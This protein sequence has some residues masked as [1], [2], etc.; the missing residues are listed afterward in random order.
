MNFMC[1]PEY[2]IEV[3]WANYGRLD[4]SRCLEG[5]VGGE[6]EA[7]KNCTYESVLDILKTACNGHRSCNYLTDRFV[8]GNPCPKVWSYLDV[9]YTCH[10]K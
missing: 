5:A 3:T 1:P 10:R 7:S 4:Q 6:M 9:E 8:L 2:V